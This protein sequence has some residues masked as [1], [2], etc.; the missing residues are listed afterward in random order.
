MSDLRLV[1]LLHVGRIYEDADGNDQVAFT[2]DTV[3]VFGHMDSA[4]DALEVLA[5]EVAERTLKE[6][7]PYPAMA[8]FIENDQNEMIIWMRGSELWTE[9]ANR[10]LHTEGLYATITVAEMEE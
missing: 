2:T 3:R 1:H 7:R 6:L 5:H 4:L 8:G 10:I 9:A